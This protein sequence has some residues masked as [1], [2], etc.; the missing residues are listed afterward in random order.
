MSIWEIF[1]DPEIEVIER[2]RRDSDPNLPGPDVAALAEQVAR[3][4]MVTEG[5]WQLV[6]ERSGLHD[7]DLARV[8]VEVDRQ[9]S[10]AGEEVAER[11]CRECDAVIPANAP[12]CQF[13]GGE[14]LAPGEPRRVREP[15]P[16]ADE[17]PPPPAAA[18]PPPVAAPPPPP[19]AAASPPPV[20]APPPPPPAAASP[21][22]VAAPPP[23]P[24]PPPPAAASPP[25]VAAPPPPPPAAA[26]PPP[27]AAPPPPPA[28]APP[29]PPAAAP[30]PPPPPPPT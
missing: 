27:V 14:A 23:P 12:R 5:L 22:P 15:E 9:G 16:A 1:R 20:A 30:P 21:P 6:A 8:I 25:P 17:L 10:G 24:P 13:C 28:A 18:P 19:P 26:P 3:L 2:R 11:R 7:P 4:T 29:P